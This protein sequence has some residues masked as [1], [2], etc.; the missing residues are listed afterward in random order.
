MEEVAVVGVAGVDVEREGEVALLAGLEGMSL[1]G[2]VDLFGDAQDLAVAYK[3]VANSMLLGGGDGF[4][5]LITHKVIGPLDVDALTDYL[6]AQSPT[7]PS[8]LTRIS[9]R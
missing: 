7:A 9:G 5:T 4:T 2:R 3:V 6:G 1:G 8:S